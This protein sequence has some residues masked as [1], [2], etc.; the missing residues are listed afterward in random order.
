[1][2]LLE[3]GEEEPRLKNTQDK[4]NSKDT[5]GDLTLCD[6]CGQSYSRKANLNKHIRKKHPDLWAQ[7][8]KIK[9]DQ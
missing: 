1:M 2:V 4:W 9:R 5:A 8:L 3:G 7:E 6:E